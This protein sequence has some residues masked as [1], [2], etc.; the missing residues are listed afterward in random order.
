MRY[1]TLS[2]E[3][4][5]KGV[6]IH[7]GQASIMTCIPSGVGSGISFIYNR[8]RVPATIQTLADIHHRS[9][10]LFYQDTRI[11]TPEHI[12]SAC[13]SLC[14]Q[15][16]EIHLTHSECPILDGSALPFFEELMRYRIPLEPK[17]DDQFSLNE[18]MT[19]TLG[20]AQ[21][22]CIPNDRLI[23]DCVIQYP[24]H[25]LGTQSLVYH[26]SE[27][28]Y[29]ESIAPA[30]TYGF[31]HELTDLKSKGLAKGGSF[32]NA[33]VIGDN[34]YCNTPRFQDECVRHK[35][36]DIIGDCALLSS[37]LKMHISAVCPSHAGNC[38]LIQKLHKK[39]NKGSNRVTD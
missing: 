11:H 22:H 4:S 26:H 30:R 25:W 23:I 3:V 8:V 6:G 10:C 16:I 19:Y 31:M 18:P 36:L 7:S 27:E 9:T 13:Y 20:S 38:G 17:K 29:F 24:D 21:Y 35:I 12:L 1:F 28:N 5:F 37:D 14:L 2:E 33:L 32:E 39:Q 34:S 15:D